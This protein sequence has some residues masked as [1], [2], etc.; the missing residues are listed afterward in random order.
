MWRL[1]S[2]DIDRASKMYPE[3]KLR[4]MDAFREHLLAEADDDPAIR[5]A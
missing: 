5:Q 3:L 2:A 1:D 4:L